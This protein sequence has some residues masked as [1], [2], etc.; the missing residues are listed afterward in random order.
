MYSQSRQEIV[1]RVSSETLHE[2]VDVVFD[3][4]LVMVMKADVK[5]HNRLNQEGVFYFGV[6]CSPFR[7]ARDIDESFEDRISELFEEE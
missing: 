4:G 2:F 6:D 3:S 7:T 5:N 1:R